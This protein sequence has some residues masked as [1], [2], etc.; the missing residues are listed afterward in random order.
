MSGNRATVAFFLERG[1]QAKDQSTNCISGFFTDAYPPYS[2]PAHYAAIVGSTELLFALERRGADLT[3]LDHLSRT[4]LSYAVEKLNE[5]AVEL[6]VKRKHRN[7]S[8]WL[9]GSRVS[10]T[11]LGSGHIWLDKKQKV[12]A[13]PNPQIV[14]ALQDVGFCVKDRNNGQNNSK[15][16]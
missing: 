6:L 10:N 11:Y 12:N 1:L 14:K 9:F 5:A 2:S 7:R 16:S 15:W 4:P 13:I 3:A 8:G